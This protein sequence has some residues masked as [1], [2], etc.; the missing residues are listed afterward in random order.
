[1][2]KR[3]TI[4]DIKRANKKAGYY[5]FKDDTMECFMSVIYPEVYHTEKG[6]FFISSERV[7]KIRVYKIREF[8]PETGS[9]G[10][11]QKTVEYSTKR[12]A[13]LYLEAFRK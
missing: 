13:E 1:M 11:A 4:E 3:F 9:V 8:N 2:D 12:G 5:F 10:T 7:P 6:I